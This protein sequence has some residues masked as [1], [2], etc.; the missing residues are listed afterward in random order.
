MSE[1]KTDC[2][3]VLN[4]GSSSI[5]YGLYPVDGGKRI[6][7]GL[8]ERIGVGAQHRAEDGS[9]T[10]LPADTHAG[11]LDWLLN[12][13]SAR[14]GFMLIAAGHRVVHGGQDFDGPVRINKDALAKIHALAP[15]APAH[16]P[17]NIAGIEAVARNHPTLP[18]FA[19][20][21]TAFHRS[22]PRLEQLYALPRHLLD[23]GVLRY[24]FHGLSYDFI[25]AQMPRVMGERAAGKVAVLHLGNGASICGMVEGQSFATS[26]GFTALDGLMMGRRCGDMDP[27]VVFHLIRDRGL[28]VDEAEALLGNQSG[29]MGVSGISSDMRDLLASDAA[30]AQE[31]VQLFILTA[32][33][34]LGAI[35]AAM[36][37][38]DAMV[39][40]GGIGENAAPVRAGIVR[41]MGWLGFELD[42]AA[43]D[44]GAATITL[45]AQSAGQNTGQNAGQP[46]I[47]SA[48]VIA[49]NEERVIADQARTLLTG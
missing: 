15:L 31:A 10:A 37:G 14:G 1:A 25:A 28:S 40:T 30:E 12:M 19:S 41:A 46:P 16:Q 3:L 27:G 36:G 8:I 11:A 23:D 49:T 18:Q 7:R 32:A 24:G 42:E 17:H 48:H 6:L 29:L 47:K 13:L 33:K 20:F 35:T 44:A 5:K 43:N 4:S 21:D 2:I 22:Q 9:V 39:F 26:M 38:L 34:Q 45:P